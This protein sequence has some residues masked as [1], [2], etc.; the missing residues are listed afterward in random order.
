MIK[1]D[2][3]YNLKFKL[4]YIFKRLNL[5]IDLKALDIS[6]NNKISRKAIISLKANV[7]SKIYPIA[8]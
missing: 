7:H 3:I 2:I 1:N 4:L 5:S 6:F 8:L